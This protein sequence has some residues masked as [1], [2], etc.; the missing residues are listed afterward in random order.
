MNKVNKKKLLLFIICLLFFI[1]YS[2]LSVI[3]HLHYGSFGYDLGIDD[4]VVWEYSKFHP[5]ITT[6]GEVPF[7]PELFT[8]LEFIYILL[9]P[10]YWIYNNAKTLLILQSFF[11]TISALPIYWLARRHKLSYFL[12]FSLVLSYLT[13]YG[14]QNALWIDVHSSAFGA[15]LLAWFIYFID[16]KKMSLSIVFFLLT[17]LCKENFAA[18]LL[19]VSIVYFV[20]RHEKIQLFFIGISALYLF[21]IFGIYFPHIVPGG[22]RFQSKQGLLNSISLFDLFNTPDKQSV[23]FYTFGWTGG[24]A[25]IQP[26]FVIPIIGSLASYFI[27]GRDVPGTQTIFMQYR[28]ELAPLLFLATIYGIKRLRKINMNILGLYIL[29]LAAYMQYTLHLPLSYL[30]KSWFWQTPKSTKTINTMIQVIPENASIVAQNNII[31]HIS[32]RY[33]IFTLWPAKKTFNKNSP[34]KKNVCNWLQWTDNPHY[35]LIDTSSDWD[36]RHFLV[37]REDFIDSISNLERSGV[38]KKWK[39]EKNTYLYKVLKKP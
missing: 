12:S 4:Q 31:P 21:L 25:F 37:N 38:I 10:F 26:L 20:Y 6:I 3:R 39:Q 22:Y 5:P 19:L 35:L 1:S 17:M 23:I 32:H 28:I 11:V 15:S 7:I 34:C 8:H 16:I 14:I 33:N 27:L 2:T 36:A 18:L 13:F 24:I 29:I 30:T 9:A